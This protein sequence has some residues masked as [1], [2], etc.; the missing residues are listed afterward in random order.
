MIEHDPLLIVLAVGA[1]CR[2][3]R[4]VTADSILDRPRELAKR[5]SEKLGL[6]IT[7]PWCVSMWLAAATIVC[8]LYWPRWSLTVFAILTASYV[9]GWLA[10]HE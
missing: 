4:L 10:G 3:T 6:F 2:L 9:A 1:V 7:C 8:A 5:R